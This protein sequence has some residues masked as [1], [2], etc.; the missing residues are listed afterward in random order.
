MGIFENP[1]KLGGM[2]IFKSPP[3]RTLPTDL[4]T[5]VDTCIRSCPVCP[6]DNNTYV[7]TYLATYLTV[8]VRII[9]PSYHDD[10]LRVF[11]RGVRFPPYIS[12]PPS[13]F[14]ADRGAEWGYRLV[15][16][17]V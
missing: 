5:T 13:L 3:F 11:H 2:R 6:F 15:A 7:R 8:D 12:F 10:V 14:C 16:L 17:F 9:I 1:H 4:C